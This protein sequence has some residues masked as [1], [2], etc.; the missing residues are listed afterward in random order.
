MNGT[1]HEYLPGLNAQGP[2]LMPA[3]FVKMVQVKN[4]DADIYSD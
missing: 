3:P 4:Y 2:A 1:L